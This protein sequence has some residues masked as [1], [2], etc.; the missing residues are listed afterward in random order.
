VVFIHFVGD[1]VDVH[2]DR[3]HFYFSTHAALNRMSLLSH[4]TYQRV[5]VYLLLG[6]DY[7]QEYWWQTN[8]NTRFGIFSCGG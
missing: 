2:V 4:D 7:L 8:S 1:T 5:L 6:D 3:C